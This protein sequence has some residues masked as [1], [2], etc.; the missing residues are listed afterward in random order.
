M[1]RYQIPPG[2]LRH[3]VLQ[4]EIY[5]V[6]RRD[7]TLL[8]GS[9]VE[10]VGFDKT[11]T[12]A[13]RASLGAAAGA[14]LPGLAGQ[15]VLQHWAGLRP[16]SGTGMPIIGAHP[17]VRGLYASTGHFRTGVMLAPGSARLLADLILGR[18]PIVAPEPFAWPAR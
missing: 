5:V 10:H 6:P 9:T 7:G 17:E 13:A 11:V 1:L 16:G 8:V 4:D 14:L 2:T 3:I 12:S 15:P 18:R